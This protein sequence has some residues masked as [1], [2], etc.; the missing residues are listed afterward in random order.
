MRKYINV[1]TVR[2]YPREKRVPDK[3]ITITS[4]IVMIEYKNGYDAV[5]T[6]QHPV[7]KQILNLCLR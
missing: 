5:F 4:K 7:A 1:S 2:R 6:H 3:R